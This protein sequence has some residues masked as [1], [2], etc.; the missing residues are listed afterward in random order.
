MGGMAKREPWS[1]IHRRLSA[2]DEDRLSATDLDALADA[3]FWLDRPLESAEMWHRAYLA[4][5]ERDERAEA[6]MA[7]WRAFY[8]H[9]QIGERAVASGWLARMRDLAADT[10]GS[11]EAGYVALAE[12]SWAHVGGDAEMAL[13]PCREAVATGSERDDPN[14]TA[15]A[16]E[17]QGR[18]LIELGEV[19]QGLGLLDAAMLSVLGEDLDPLFEGWIYC[20]L[21]ST[22]RGLA[23]LERASEWTRAAMRWC[24]TLAEGRV[25]AGI[26][27]VHQVE[28]DCLHGDWSRAE[29]GITRACADLLAVDPRY[30]GEAHYVA[31]E[32]HRLRGEYDAAESAYRRAH[33]LGR[34]PQPGLALLR[35]A[36]GQAASALAALRESSVCREGPPIHRA[37]SLAALVAAELQGGSPERAHAAMG[38]LSQVTDDNESSY[39]RAIE[40]HCQGSV[41]AAEDRPEEAVTALRTARRL[42]T[43][44]G[45]PREIAEVGLLLGQLGQRAGD[46]DGARLELEAARATFA[47]LGA[48]PS[49]ATADLL[50]A[51]TAADR[52]GLSERELEVLDLV[53]RGRTDREIA[54]E[55]VISEHT[56]ARHVSNIRTKLG[57]STRAAATGYAYTH[58][59]LHD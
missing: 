59:L 34:D 48:A 49:L 25:Y 55:L 18:L 9:L 57:V 3:L 17:T 15:L 16:I 28:L 33:E 2:R 41:L 24:D 31:G 27:R 38:S 40:A 56:V 7:A 30:A 32:L 26:C 5:M 10:P 44:L 29:E 37:R 36:G 50:L 58:G 13:G 35:L 21:L 6:T 45:M 12:A 20:E 42:F 4:H 1:E 8:E 11:L 22:C 54:A 19:A 39:L 53:A 46:I 14:L 47:R 23:D 52:H 43:E 51:G